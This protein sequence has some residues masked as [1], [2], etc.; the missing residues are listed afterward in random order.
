MIN[1]LDLFMDW[2]IIRIASLLHVTWCRRMMKKNPFPFTCLHQT[3]LSS[4]WCLEMMHLHN[5]HVDYRI[6]WY[7]DRKIFMF[8]FTSYY[9]RIDY[10]ISK[11]MIIKT[12]VI[13]LFFFLKS[14]GR[15][16]RE[17]S[18][19]IA[20]CFSQWGCDSHNNFKVRLEMAKRNSCWSHQLYHASVIL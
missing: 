10:Q 19:D 2:L 14:Q 9:Y 11:I 1:T 20:S 6:H 16:R 7:E 18:Y 15:L 4:L 17:F 5:T 12:S 8:W 13:I 3:S